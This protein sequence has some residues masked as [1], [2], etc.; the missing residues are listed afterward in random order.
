MKITTPLGGHFSK[1][2]KTPKNLYKIESTNKLTVNLE[3][4]KDS[5]VIKNLSVFKE[6]ILNDDIFNNSIIRIENNQ[7]SEL[8]TIVKECECNKSTMHNYTQFYHELLKDY[9][10]DILNFIEIGIGT[11][12]PNVPSSMHS[13]YKIGSSLLAWETYFT[14]QNMKIYGGDID[15]KTLFETDRIDTFYIN[16]ENPT[17]IL[18]FLKNFNL[19]EDG[20]DFI[21]D[22]G[23][24]QLHSN[25]M[26]LITVWPYLKIN[27]LYLIEDISES[28][29]KNLMYFI[30][31]YSLNASCLAIESPSELK[32]DNRMIILQKNKL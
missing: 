23:L 17:S 31:A 27:G 28:E 29:F 7:F 11:T 4:E 1:N 8:C 16:Q 6:N 13:E 21:L 9:R 14:N 5:I 24:H 12:D 3:N 25:L 30:N 15:P 10:N 32:T 18:K 20:I 19:D 26:L 22:D 2:L